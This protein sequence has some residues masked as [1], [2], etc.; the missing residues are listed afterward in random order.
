MY[1]VC[2]YIIVH[3]ICDTVVFIFVVESAVVL[4]WS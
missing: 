2:F 1:N 3:F 4:N